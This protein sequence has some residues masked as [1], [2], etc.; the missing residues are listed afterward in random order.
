MPLGAAAEYGPQLPASR[1]SMSTRSA[2]R[3]RPRH[4]V[5]LAALS[6]RVEPKLAPRPEGHGQNARPRAAQR[7]S[8]TRHEAD[9]PGGDAT[10]PRYH[11]TS[12][13]THDVP[14]PVGPT[15]VGSTR[16]GAGSRAQCATAGID[17]SCRAQ[18]KPRSEFSAILAPPSDAVDWQASRRHSVDGAPL[19]P[20][21]T[22][23][24]AEA[25]HPVFGDAQRAVAPRHRTTSAETAMARARARSLASTSSPRMTEA[26]RGTRRVVAFESPSSAPLDAPPKRR[27][28]RRELCDSLGCA[29]ALLGLTARL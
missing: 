2:L 12:N 22:R 15:E 5:G 26:V 23:C 27:V 17:A 25:S 7:R 14:P 19:S 6:P 3:P 24:S 21:L 8:A 9:G 29:P 1:A 28:T 16:G 10:P 20:P 18:P 11:H 13:H 4:G